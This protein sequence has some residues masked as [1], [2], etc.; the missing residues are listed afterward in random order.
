MASRSELRS[1]EDEIP[2]LE[3]ELAEL[4]ERL[5]QGDRH[6]EALEGLSQGIKEKRQAIEDLQG[7][8]D[9][10]EAALKEGEALEGEW[11]SA[12]EELQAFRSEEES[13]RKVLEELKT[14]EKNIEE[15]EEAVR[16]ARGNLSEKELEEEREKRREASIRREL[17][18]EV[19]PRLSEIGERLKGL[20]GLR[21]TLDLR[22]EKGKQQERRERLEEAK[23]NRE[24]IREQIQSQLAP[25]AED[26]ENYRMVSRKLDVTRAKAEAAA[27][28]VAFDLPERVE[29]SSDPPA[30]LQEDGEYL[31]TS[32]T[33]FALSDLGTVTVSGG[34]EDLKQLKGDLESLEESL[35]ALQ[36]QFGLQDETGFVAAHE[37]KERLQRDLET[38]DSSI[39][40]MLEQGD[41]VD[42]LAR[43]EGRLR[44]TEARTRKLNAEDLELDRTA[45]SQEI[46][47]LSEEMETLG[48]RRE[49]LSAEAGQARESYHA[50]IEA[51]SDA[52]SGLTQEEATLDGYRRQ[53]SALLKPYGD[54]QHLNARLKEKAE[55][56][57][58][59]EQRWEG[60]RTAVQEEVEKP[61]AA[62][63]DLQ[64]QIGGI[65]TS[66]HEDEKKETG[67]LSALETL[68]QGNLYSQIGDLEA[69]VE[70]K[71]A[72]LRTLQRRADGARIL[73]N[74]VQEL[75]EERTGVLAGPVSERLS[76]WLAE[77]TD[78]AYEGVT[79]STE[80]K[81]AEVRFSRYGADLE[82]GELSHGTQ[83]QLVVLLRLAIATALSQEERQLVVLDDRLVNS[84]PVR[85]RRLRPILQE[86]SESCQI[87]LAT[88][89]ETPYA[90]LPG[91]VIRVPEDGRG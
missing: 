7:E 62:L 54:R 59:Q 37:A 19:G 26:L 15:A 60:L 87:L 90:G 42:E 49:E 24:E 81:P 44:E 65:E 4:Q 68:S 70:V 29:I 31:I 63:A 71:K 89:N 38:I 82:V 27:I 53:V 32:S 64:N 69:S 57:S 14:L 56:V 22:E 18:D 83:E 80:L 6:R 10:L 84:D 40:T 45:V 21:D 16:T 61:R 74:L 34:G 58:R 51:K 33:R 3:A 52:K 35:T 47:A 25:S 77:L 55:D 39:Q 9:A 41:P 50:A 85:M 11:R 66:L 73:W 79:L 8:A 91:R 76:G 67:V 36:D 46:R 88:C 43:M 20:E 86:A 12:G 75:Q 5:S 17:Q 1:L 48:A 13:L 30:E 72:R 2:K 78:G 28:R 23:R